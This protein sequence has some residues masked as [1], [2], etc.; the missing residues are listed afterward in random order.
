[1]RD[2]CPICGAP[3]IANGAKLTLARHLQVA[4]ERAASKVGRRDK[5]LLQHV[6]RLNWNG[7]YF[8][9]A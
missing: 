4:T 7:E 6:A 9:R 5:Q 3:F 8:G 2:E 1:M